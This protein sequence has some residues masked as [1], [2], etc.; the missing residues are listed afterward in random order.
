[1]GVVVPVCH[2]GSFSPLNKFNLRE[3]VSLIPLLTGAL[4]ASHLYSI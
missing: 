4:I 1:M 3:T 2:E